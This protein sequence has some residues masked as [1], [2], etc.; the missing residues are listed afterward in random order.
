MLYDTTT[1][2]YDEEAFLGII[3]MQKLQ[4]VLMMHV[5]W[6]LSLSLSLRTSSLSFYIM[7]VCVWVSTWTSSSVCV[8]FK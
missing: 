1:C 7:C 4:S 2:N 8:G 3:K 6:K 5:Y